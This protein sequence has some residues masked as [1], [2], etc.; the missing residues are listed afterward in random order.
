MYGVEIMKRRV[1]ARVSRLIY[2]LAA[3]C[4]PGIKEKG[5][6]GSSFKLRFDAGIISPPPLFPLGVGECVAEEVVSI[7]IHFNALK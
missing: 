4:Q 2:F 7:E 6:G 5:G 3:R 1:G